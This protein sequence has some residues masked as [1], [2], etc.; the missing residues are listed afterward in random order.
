MVNGTRAVSING[1]G[2]QAQMTLAPYSGNIET[3]VRQ[4]FTTL[5]GQNSTLAPAQL[6]RTTVNGLPAAFGTAR[7]NS[8]NNQVDVTVFAYEFARDRAYHFVA[9]APAGR[10]ATFNPMFQSMRRVTASE[11]GNIV[12]KKLQIVTVQRGDTVASL[13]RRMSYPA[14]QEERFRVL[15]GLA[16]SEGVTAGQKVKLVVRAR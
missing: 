14:A 1:Q 13:A 3:Y 16:S 11:A 10:A 8:G 15:N 9:I 2:G 6:Q 7:V 5:G 12:P 4:Q